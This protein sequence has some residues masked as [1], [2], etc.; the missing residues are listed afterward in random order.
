MAISW[1]SSTSRVRRLK[2]PGYLW[3]NRYSPEHG[4]GKGGVVVAVD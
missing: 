2:K 4:M 3:N 1:L